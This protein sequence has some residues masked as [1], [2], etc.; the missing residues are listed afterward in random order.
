MAKLYFRYSA[1]NAGKTTQVL[2]IKYNY[3]ERGQHVLLL[4]SAIDSREGAG[5]IKSRIGLEGE[6]VVVHVTDDLFELVKQ[7]TPAAPI[8]HPQA[9][10]AALRSG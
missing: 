2:Q 3:E 6:A 10:S 7:A 9:D 8:F 4:K 1:M 5:R